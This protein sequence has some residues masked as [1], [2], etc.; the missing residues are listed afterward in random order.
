MLGVQFSSEGYPDK[1]RGEAEKD[2]VFL[3]VYMGGVRSP[4]FAEQSEDAVVECAKKEVSEMLGV[5]GEPCFSRAHIWKK[6]IPQY[7]K[8]HDY[9]L[10]TARRLE[11]HAPGLVLA[12]NY[13]DG[14]GLPDALLSGLNAAERA[15]EY[16]EKIRNLNDPSGEGWEV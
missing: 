8:Y 14:V 16:I 3:T 13:K 4:K 15:L 2:K 1:S 9:V 5:K 7:D 11:R 6:G 10:Y 12:G